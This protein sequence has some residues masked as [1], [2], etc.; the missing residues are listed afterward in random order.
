[1]NRIKIK[2]A[3]SNQR[4]KRK[5]C[6][7]KR[8][9][10]EIEFTDGSVHLSNHCLLCGSNLF[11][12]K[13]KEKKDYNQEILATLDLCWRNSHNLNN[14]QKL[15]LE[16]CIQQFEK[17]NWLSFKQM[18]ILNSFFQSLLTKKSKDKPGFD[19]PEF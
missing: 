6:S 12:K 13:E 1:M 3:S 16:S 4:K 15:F 17:K 18:N 10:V 5:R 7:H 8:E 2:I 19:L 11:L 9:V 14:R